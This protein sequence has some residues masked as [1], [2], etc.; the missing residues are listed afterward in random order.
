TL[1]NKTPVHPQRTITITVTDSLNNPI[2]TQ[3]DVFTYDP[4]KGLYTGTAVLGN[5]VA[6]D[7]Y[8]ITLKTTT[9]LKKTIP[10]IQIFHGQQTPLTAISLTAGDV[11]NDETLDMLDYN[12]II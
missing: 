5:A 3:Q 10:G 1:S 4:A 11:N 6:T 8:G 9:F 2:T 12:S 7:K